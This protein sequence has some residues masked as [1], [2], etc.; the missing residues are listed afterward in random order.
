MTIAEQFISECKGKSVKEIADIEQEYIEDGLIDGDKQMF[1]QL[2][3]HA[4]PQTLSNGSITI[5]IK[6]TGVLFVLDEDDRWYLKNEVE[7]YVVGATGIEQVEGTGWFG[8]PEGDYFGFGMAAYYKDGADGEG[9]HFDVPVDITIIEKIVNNL[10]PGTEIDNYNGWYI[11]FSW[12][13]EDN[14]RFCDWR[15]SDGSTCCGYDVA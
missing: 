4:D 6:D 3:M 14:L 8:Y 5:D 10:A 13:V 15:F 12:W 11:T 7:K 1:D 9:G 2:E